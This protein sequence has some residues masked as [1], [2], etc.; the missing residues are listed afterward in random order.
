LS[1]VLEPV[2][3]PSNQSLYCGNCSTEM[4]KSAGDEGTHRR[5]GDRVGLIALVNDSFQER[6]TRDGYCNDAGKSQRMSHKVK[7]GELLTYSRPSP[8]NMR[9]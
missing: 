6:H 4:T 3:D 5:A 1:L 9:S 7:C 8:K 2:H